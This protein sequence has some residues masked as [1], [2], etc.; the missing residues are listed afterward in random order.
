MI[1]LEDCIALSGITQQQPMK[2]G[3]CR[4]RLQFTGTPH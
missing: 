1:G 4:S 2:S 3:A